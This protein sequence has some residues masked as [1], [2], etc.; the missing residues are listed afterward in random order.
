MRRD[1]VV[2]IVAVAVGVAGVAIAVDGPPAASEAALPEPSGSAAEALVG[3][4][5]T[6]GF[7]PGEGFVPGPVGGQAGWFSWTLSDEPHIDT[8]NP[9][10]GIQHVRICW[11]PDVSWGIE[12][13]SPTVVDTVADASWF[14]V[15]VHIGA[16]GG[17][18][19]VVILESVREQAT[20]A[21]VWFESDGDIKVLERLPGGAWTWVDTGIDWI[22]GS[23]EELE[24][25]VDP[26]DEEMQYSYGSSSYYSD[27]VDGTVVER[28]WLASDNVQ[29]TVNADFDD[30]FI[31]RGRVGPIVHRWSFTTDGSDS[32]GGADAVL[33]NGAHIEGGAL[34][35]DGIDDYAEL[36][37]LDTLRLLTDVSVE[38]WVT[39]NSSRSWERFFDFGDNENI[40]WFMTPSASQT[41]N[42]RVAITATGNPGE[43]RT[44]APEPFPYGTR[45][46][47]A[48]TLDG[49]GS[50]DQSKLYINGTLV[51]VHHEDSPLDPAEIGPFAN[52]YLGK[53]QYAVDPYL[54]GAIDEFVIHSIV[55][56]DAEVLEHYRAIFADGFD[57]GDASAWLATQP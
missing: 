52:N 6:W 37:I 15:W 24:I 39:W 30:L 54:T 33:H 29:N 12:A 23:Y 22:P 4:V 10:S 47:V 11:E 38:M 50:S 5:E 55:L 41:G 31:D 51:A 36:P 44:D 46:H 3:L 26:L 1:L 53:S 20:T 35:L 7:E 21:R 8:A 9:H 25:R 32:V 2:T 34:V 14:S 48:Y 57:G 40:N 56:T 42:P 43:Q 13:V 18:G 19:Y 27:V 17:A 49:D 16:T 45:T 28:V